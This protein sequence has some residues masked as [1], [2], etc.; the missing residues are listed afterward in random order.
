MESGGDVTGGDGFGD[1]WRMMALSPRG[2][3]VSCRRWVVACHV[4]EGL[5]HVMSQKGWG[6]AVEW[7]CDS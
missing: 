2:C 4:A 7:C 5:P 3:H 1:M 6:S